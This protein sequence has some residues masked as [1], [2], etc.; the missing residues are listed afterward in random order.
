M[1]ALLSMWHKTRVRAQFAWRFSQ[2]REGLDRYRVPTLNIFSE[3]KIAQYLCQ[4]WV[5]LQF[6]TFEDSWKTLVGQ[7]IFKG[8][9]RG[10]GFFVTNTLH[11]KIHTN[12]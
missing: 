10:T 6:N 8:A 3:R 1:N 7:P 9:F 2:H 5:H 12:M 11:W 4:K